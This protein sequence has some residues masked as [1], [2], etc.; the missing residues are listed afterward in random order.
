MTKQKEID[1]NKWL[2]FTIDALHDALDKY[3]IGKL[4]GPLWD[5]IIGN[6]ISSGGEVESIIIKFLQYG[7]FRDM[8]VGKGVKIGDALSGNRNKAPWFSKTKVHQISRLRE[9]MIMSLSNKAIGE[10]ESG[11][12]KEITL[13]V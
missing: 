9:L 4:D 8:R 11:L 6:V 7:R 12:S 2:E 1:Y 13:I 5:S 10:I 3:N